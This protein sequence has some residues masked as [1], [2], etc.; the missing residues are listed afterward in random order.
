MYQRLYLV[1]P[2]RDGGMAGHPHDG[3]AGSQ[4]AN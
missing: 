4:R 2:W 3:R 1:R